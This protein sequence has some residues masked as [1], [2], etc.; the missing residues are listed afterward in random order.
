MKAKKLD[1]TT[2]PRKLPTQPKQEAA[3]LRCLLWALSLLVI[4]TG[5]VASL[6][7]GHRKTDLIDFGQF[8]MGGLIAHASAWND[9]YPQPISGSQLNAGYPEGSKMSP[10]YQKIANEKGVG[11]TYRYINPPPT[12]LLLW[13]LSLFQP[14]RAQWIWILAMTVCA[15][16]VAVSA[17]LSLERL[18][19]T[20]IFA[21][22][23]LAVVLALS[24]RMIRSICMGN[25]SPLVA[26]AT[27]LAVAGLASKRPPAGAAG[28]VLG[29]ITKYA[30][31]V[32]L[33][34][35]IIT[36]RWRM[37]LATAALGLA[38]ILT[39]GLITGASP[40]IYFSTT[41]A[42]T[43]SRAPANP[44]N[45]SLLSTIAQ[46]GNSET[47]T[48]NERLGSLCA[49]TLTLVAILASTFHAVSRLA[50]HTLVTVACAALYAWLLIFSPI[51]WQH[52]VL[53][54]Y[55]FWGW[56]VCEAIKTGW[57][58]LLAIFALVVTWMP[59]SIFIGQLVG[60]K[61]GAA[62][63]ASHYL[64]LAM[65]AIVILAIYRLTSQSAPDSNRLKE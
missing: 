2:S 9:L 17:G 35:M 41:I 57:P 63:V 20:P 3:P 48:K 8:Y 12:A 21:G 4:L 61:L 18:F 60:G 49:Q 26:V 11:D 53:Y 47:P 51:F 36:R 54:I 25:I 37:L 24:P 10:L 52:Y 45:E 5:V 29:A 58:R 30:T 23:A 59:S 14:E 19:P 38:V 33:P 27:A 28:V 1:H 13:P 6:R 64:I 56:L 39:S 43:F 42:P 44:G 65:F 16:L 50:H 32:I 46:L 55:P 22:P 31:V 62:V 40:F 34:V 7:L 15:W